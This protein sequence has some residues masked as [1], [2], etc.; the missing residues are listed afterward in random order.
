MKEFLESA[1]KLA[2]N[3]LGIV[4]LLITLV[5][6]IAG[7]AATSKVFDPDERKILVIFLVVFPALVLIAIYRFVTKHNDKLYAPSDFSD[8]NH[9]MRIVESQLKKS[10]TIGVIESELVDLR[11]FEES[12]SYLHRG[13]YA[14]RQGK[15]E[16]AIEHYDQAIHI[17]AKNKEAH[18][19]KGFALKKLGKVDEAFHCADKAISLSENYEAALYNR[20]CYRCVLGHNVELVLEDLRRSI[21]I[22]PE[23]KRYAREDSDFNSIK[24]NADFKRITL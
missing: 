2:R 10:P 19:Q 7:L 12:N 20:A 3:P 4:A 22:N 17:Y 13:Y 6:A 14:M 1:V 9:F 8:E 18:L 11:L 15:A 16:F 23:N 21:K 5:Y 24:D